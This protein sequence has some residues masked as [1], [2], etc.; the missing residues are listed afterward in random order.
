MSSNQERLVELTRE[1][2]ASL[3]YHQF[4][5]QDAEE[6]TRL[7]N[8][9]VP[10]DI[11]A[12]AYETVKNRWIEQG[13]WNNN[14]NALADGVWK[15]QEPLEQEPESGT[16]SKAESLPRPSSSPTSQ[17]QPEPR[18]R[19]KSEDE[20]R[21]IAERRV[22]RERERQASRPYYQ[23]VYQISRE[24]ER[25]EEETKNWGG[26][27]AAGINTRAYGNVKDTWVKRGIWNRKWGILPGMTWKHEE[28]LDTEADPVSGAADL[29]M[30]R[31]P[32]ISN[33]AVEAS[34]P[35]IFC[36]PSFADQDHLQ[37]FDMMNVLQQ[38]QSADLTSVA[39]ETGEAE[40]SPFRFTS[41]QDLIGGQ[42]F[43]P[44]MGQWSNPGPSPE[45]SPVAGESLDRPHSGKVSKA[46]GKQR[47]GPPQQ[48]H[49]SHEVSSDD[50]ALSSAVDTPEPQMEP[51][52]ATPRRSKRLRSRVPN[53]AEEHTRTAS[54][55]PTKRTSHS[56]PLRSVAGD[57]TA[58]SSAKPKG[59]SRRQRAKPTRKTANQSRSHSRYS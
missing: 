10:V 7:Q 46:A 56:M 55:D 45:D 30:N 12:T 26:A 38:G 18:R 22:V 50:P 1:H 31:Q 40:H 20:R 24:R 57:P 21:R 47:P 25:I 43:Q 5:D 51:V 16:D 8:A 48:P 11:A 32:P 41:P 34:P 13:I 53:V 44:A 52:R 6:R 17:T 2:R 42:V 36:S 4:A 37:E 23:F 27:E 54:T 28:P 35:P 59:I 29:L 3:P 9:F 49:V 14:W 33:E 58:R 39:L 15:H 19:P